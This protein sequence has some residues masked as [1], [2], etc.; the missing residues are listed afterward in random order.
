MSKYSSK[1]S[2]YART[3]TRKAKR[4]RE[5]AFLRRRLEAERRHSAKLERQVASLKQELQ[6][7]RAYDTDNPLRRIRHRPST[8]ERHREAA[9]KRAFRYR[10]GSYVRY[11]WDALTDSF[12]LRM[13]SRLF[14]YLR[15][16]RVVNMIITIA[17]A[18]GAVAVVTVVSAAVLPFL[19]VGTLGLAMLAALRSRR[20]NV[21][22]RRELN[23]RHI[24]VIVLPR[25]A[26]QAS[27][28]FSAR[29]ARAMAGE[30]N[31]AVVVITP[32]LLSTRGF[33]GHGQFF[34]ARRECSDLY[35][36]RRHYYFILRRRV[37]DVV[38][39]N[40]TVIY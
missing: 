32:Y 3:G 4:D 39:T 35:L 23:D 31:V 13:A 21:I 38:D 34:T 40:M 11:L 14:A 16:L 18:I 37:L 6:E 12:L 2:V 22:L 19:L 29:Q 25:G 30:E 17:L 8:E 1:P 20:M 10:N 27:D 26:A 33:G 36:V 5:I 28:S 9:A 24:R 7:C 15:R